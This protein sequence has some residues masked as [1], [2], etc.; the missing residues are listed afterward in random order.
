MAAQ[1]CSVFGDALRHVLS[2]QFQVL[3]HKSTRVYPYLL[4]MKVICFILE[5]CKICGLIALYME[6]GQVI[7]LINI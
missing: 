2:N 4:I 6:Q 1:V 7:K 5:S 3:C